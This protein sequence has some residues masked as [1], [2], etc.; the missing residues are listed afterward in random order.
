M[1]STV[2][3]DHWVKIK[4]NE[5]QV[6]RPFQ[7]TKK[8]LWNMGITVIPIVISAV[9]TV[10]KDLGRGLEELKIEGQI[11]TNT[12]YCIVKIH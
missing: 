2:P 1:D 10:L 8:K 3:A 12:N 11:E 9:G 4:D 5:R 6:L 7:K